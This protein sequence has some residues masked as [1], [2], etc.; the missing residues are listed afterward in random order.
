[1]FSVAFHTLG[2]KVNQVETNALSELFRQKGFKIVEFGGAADLYVVNT[3]CVT[4]TSEQKARQFIRRA[5]KLNPAAPILVTGCYAQ[6]APE[7]LL[8]MPGV[9]LVSGTKGRMEIADSALEIMEKKPS[10]V[11]RVT[12]FTG[13]EDFEE[14]TA[15]EY[16]GR[17]RATLKI[18][19]G[20]DNYC[21]YCVV[22]LARGPVRS[23]APE[24]AL[25]R[26]GE[27]AASGFKEVVLSG[28]HLGLYGKD[29]FGRAVL[30]E[31]VRDAVRIPGLARLRLGSLDPQ[32]V[33]EELLELM[34]GDTILCPHFH[35]SLQ[36]GSDEI[37][38]RMGR[39]YDT[40]FFADVAGGIRR[41]ARRETALS[42][43]L[44]VGF[45]GET[46]ALFAETVSFIKKIGFSRLHIF[47]FSTRPGT[48]AS[49]MDGQVSA[50]IK[51][52]RAAAVKKVADEMSYAFHRRFL[53]KSV[54]VLA[55]EKKKENWTG[56]NIQYVQ[57]FFPD[58]GTD[59]RNKLVRVRVT[60][61][62]RGGLYGAVESA[63]I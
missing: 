10:P 8:A 4:K 38:R 53:G 6:I 25:A 60:R 18:Q 46:E 30:A 32:D 16:A 41:R 28:V 22:P 56:Y 24:R 31:L 39:R 55:E 29:L 19:E 40:A 36:S 17:T 20:C 51:K 21:A 61:A 52:E 49:S 13:R 11:N 23:M 58:S 59:W 37:L 62:A 47:P 27:M 26:I 5:H 45:P 33:T 43:D 44:I 63:D 57:V 3:C 12:P 9:S 42:T 1:M 2:C 50:G 7:R 34:A 14:I 48:P 54:V 35:L 15:A